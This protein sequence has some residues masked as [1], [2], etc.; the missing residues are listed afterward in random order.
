MS[1]APVVKSEILFVVPS[2]HGDL[3]TIQVEFRGARP[4]GNLRFKYAKNHS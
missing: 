2:V 1:S 3:C 4:D